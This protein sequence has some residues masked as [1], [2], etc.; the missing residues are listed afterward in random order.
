[1][2]ASAP[3]LGHQALQADRGIGLLL[4]RDVVV[5]RDRDTT[6]V[7]V[8]DPGAMV[9]LTGPPALESVAED[10]PARLD[11][12]L[13]RLPGPAPGPGPRSLTVRL[14]PAPRGRGIRMPLLCGDQPYR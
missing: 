2:G 10:A 3:P 6:L 1:M 8:L 4:P 11:A 13:A 7:Q 12:A 9:T 14:A 5:R